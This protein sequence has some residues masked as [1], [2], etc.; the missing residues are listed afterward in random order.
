MARLLRVLVVD[1]VARPNLKQKGIRFGYRG[2]GGRGLGG[3][4]DN[5]TPGASPGSRF[6]QSLHSRFSAHLR[7][8]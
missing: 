1:S 3:V 5:A 8:G 4:T 6:R 7:K 2:D